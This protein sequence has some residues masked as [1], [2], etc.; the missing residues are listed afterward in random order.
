VL[1]K[2]K[3]GDEN[4]KQLRQRGIFRS[5]RRSSSEFGEADTEGIH[6]LDSL[7]RLKTSMQIYVDIPVFLI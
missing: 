2:A 4:A 7:L 6:F 5:P 1:L 3:A